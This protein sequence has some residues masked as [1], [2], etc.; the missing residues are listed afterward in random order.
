MIL[1]PVS[2]GALARRMDGYMPIWSPDGSELFF[3]SGRQHDRLMSAR[4]ITGSEDWRN[5]KTEFL[6][7]VRMA[8]GIGHALQRYDVT[9]DRD[10]FV[11]ATAEE[12]PTQIRM[13]LDWRSQ[14]ATLFGQK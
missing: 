13:V 9:P 6:L 14:L 4:V 7:Q 1:P 10:R 8:G 3:F 12:P 2:G 11:F 5:S